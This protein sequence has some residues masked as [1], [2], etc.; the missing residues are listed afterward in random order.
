MKNKFRAHLAKNNITG[1]YLAKLIGVTHKTIYN[2]IPEDST[3]LPSLP[4]AY[5]IANALGV[6]PRDLWDIE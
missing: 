6:E 5:K 4:L 2:L 1:Y 3:H